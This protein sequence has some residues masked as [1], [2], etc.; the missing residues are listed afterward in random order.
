[1]FSYRYESLRDSAT[2][3]TSTTPTSTTNDTSLEAGPSGIVE[4]RMASAM[5]QLHDA[6]PAPAP[7]PLQCEC[8][9]FRECCAALSPDQ[10]PTTDEFLLELKSSL[11]RAQAELQ[12]RIVTCEDDRQM[13]AALAENDSVDLAMAA[14]HAATTRYQERRQQATAPPVVSAQPTPQ[15]QASELMDLL[16][17]GPEI[18]RTETATPVMPA[19]MMQPIKPTQPRQPELTRTASAAEFEDFFSNPSSFNGEDNAPGHQLAKTT[20]AEDFENFFKNSDVFDVGSSNANAS[21]PRT[22]IAAQ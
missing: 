16:G 17:H 15:P 12:S 3:P 10:D 21:T 2:S 20:S 6:A 18:A 4:H 11:Q 22:C 8:E 9:L 7:S 13:M 5:S 1:M 19:Q 14:H